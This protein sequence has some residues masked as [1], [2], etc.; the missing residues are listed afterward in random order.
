MAKIKNQPNNFRLLNSILSAM[1]WLTSSEIA[2][3]EGGQTMSEV[4]EPIEAVKLSA[5][6]RI[7]FWRAVALCAAYGKVNAGDVEKMVL[8]S[9]DEKATD[10]DVERYF[11]LAKQVASE[12]K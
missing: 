3:A 7:K 6:K 12:A 2:I 8:Y 11:N 5:Q 1:V 10:A 9:S 4:Q